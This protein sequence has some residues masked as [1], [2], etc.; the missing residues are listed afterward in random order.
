M[1][2]V[3]FA[4]GEFYHIYNRGVDKRRIF[5]SAAEYKRF[6]AYLY[7][8]NDTERRRYEYS[9]K[10]DQIWEAEPPK[11]RLVAIGAYCLMPNHFHLYLTP[12]V[13][14][15]ISKFMQRVLTAYTMFF[16]E[17]HERSGVL[18]Q[19]AFK[20][21]HVSDDVYA[22]YLFSYIHLNPAKLRDSKWKEKGMRDLR[23]MHRFLSEYPYSSLQEYS[24]GSHKITK[25][26]YFPAYLTSH[27]EIVDHVSDWLLTRN[28]GGSASQV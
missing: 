27:K 25:P 13:E 21:Q 10:T 6:L 23:S 1:R 18:L 24:T 12:L 3:I 28:L 8:L 7:F 19:G 11:S 9:L 17:K 22:R 5:M 20:A 26:Q 15:G 14:G 16:N 4:E 2:K